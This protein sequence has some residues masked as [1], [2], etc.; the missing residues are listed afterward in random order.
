MDIVI[1]RAAKFAQFIG[2]AFV[3]QLVPGPPAQRRRERRP[4][5]A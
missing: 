5:E 4:D 1:P 2:A 3:L